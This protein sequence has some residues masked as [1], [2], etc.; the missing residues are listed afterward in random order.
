MNLFSASLHPVTAP[1]NRTR[2]H[3]RPP[4]PVIRC[5]LALFQHDSSN[6]GEGEKSRRNCSWGK[7]I[8]AK[9]LEKAPQFRNL[10]RGTNPG[11]CNVEAWG[12][13]LFGRNCMREL[14][15]ILCYYISYISKNT[16]HTQFDRM[17]ERQDAFSWMICSSF[18]VHPKS[19][20]QSAPLISPWMSWPY[21]LKTS[22]GQIKHSTYLVESK[23][24]IVYWASIV[25]QE[26]KP[27]IS[28]NP[29]NHPALRY[30]FYFRWAK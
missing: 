27:T 2:V 22:Q 20:Y 19:L 25:Y 3:S 26:P 16:L 23:G 14:D 11:E 29:L 30:V 10:I 8:K 7:F 5:L 9:L 12:E 28:S 13:G 18:W 1:P 4:G 15:A 6:C 21:C 17:S 24:T